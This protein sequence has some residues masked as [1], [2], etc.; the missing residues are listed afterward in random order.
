MVTSPARCPGRRS[1]PS[2][3]YRVILDEHV[4]AQ[5]R[6]APAQLQGYI[7]GIIA[8]LRTDP[9]TASVA[10]P[11]IA[12]EHYRTIVFADGRGFLDYR[13]FEDRQVVVVVNLCYPP[14]NRKVLGSNPTSGSEKLQL[15][16]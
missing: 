14:R 16:G 13:V 5:L 15:I 11:V 12:G 6:D 1:R 7:D 10:F 8:F 2:L 4:R 9:S 3:V